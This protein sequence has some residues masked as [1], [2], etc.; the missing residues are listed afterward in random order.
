MFPPVHPGFGYL[1][2]AGLTRVRDDV[3]AG[4]GVVQALVVGAVIP[5]LVDQ[6]LYYLLPLPSTRTV[7]H[8]LLTIVPVS[9]LVIALVRRSDVPNGVAVGFTI[10]YLSHPLADALW[11]LLLDLNHELGFLLWPI[12]PSPDYEGTKELRSIGTVT[13]T[14]LWVE[15][16]LLAIALLVWWRDGTPGIDQ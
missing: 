7:G 9:L 6:P 15:L 5:D 8:S 14:T 11:P 12:I 10:G 4:T 16:T 13:V 2:Y 1:L 3:P